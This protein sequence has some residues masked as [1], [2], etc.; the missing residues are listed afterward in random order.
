MQG[1]RNPFI[2][3]PE[4]V[5][6]IFCDSTHVAWNPYMAVQEQG[7][8]Q[9]KI[10]PNPADSFLNITT[11]ESNDFQIFT[12]GKHLVEEG[13]LK[14]GE[15]KLPVNHLPSATYYMLV[16]DRMEKIIIQH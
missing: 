14:A 6:Y 2:D 4:L 8:I 16:G 15:N 1:N 12:L 9:L 7:P 3:H 5:H 13:T 11:T 10:G